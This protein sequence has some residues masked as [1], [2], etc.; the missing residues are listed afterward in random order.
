LLLSTSEFESAY[1][2]VPLILISYF[3]FGQSAFFSLGALIRNKTYLDSVVMIPGGVVNIIINLALIP[4]MGMYGSAVA[5][6]VSYL[7]MNF[8]YRYISKKYFEIKYNYNKVIKIYVLTLVFYMVYFVSSLYTSSLLFDMGFASLTILG[9]SACLYFFGFVQK[10]E[11]VGLV[12]GIPIINKF[13][14]KSQ[15]AD[16]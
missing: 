16:I 2:I 7:L 15:K 1:K 13:F 9:F 14:S 3:I 10:T 8:I 11:I 4:K 12:S 6:I 5:T